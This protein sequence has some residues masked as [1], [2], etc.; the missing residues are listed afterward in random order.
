MKEDRQAVAW[1]RHGLFRCGAFAAASERRPSIQHIRER[2]SNHVPG[3]E[4]LDA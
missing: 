1:E 3:P 4:Y 2:Y